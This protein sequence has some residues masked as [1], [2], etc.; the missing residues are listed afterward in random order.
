HYGTRPALI[1]L[2]EHPR[3]SDFAELLRPGG[4]AA[5]G[6]PPVTRQDGYVLS[7]GQV[8]M[9]FHHHFE[10]D[11]TLYNLPMVSELRGAIDESAVRGMW[12]DLAARHEALRSNYVEVDGEPTLRIRDDLGDFFSTVD[13]SGKPDPVAAARSLAAQS[14]AEPFDLE[15]DPLVRA[16]LVKLGPD[17]HV[18]HVTTHH[19]VNDGSSPRIFERE[20]PALYAAR[21]AG[22]PADL[23]PLPVRYRDYARWQR[24]LVASAVLDHELDYWK[25][26]LADAPVLRL[27]T[28]HPRPA[29]KNF[30]GAFHSFTIAP[31]L[32][33]DLRAVARRESVSFF[34][35][36]LA[37]FFLLMSGRSGQHDI[38][39]GTPTTGRNR[40]E[41]AGLIG[42]FNSTVALR[43]ELTG[44][45]D[46][47]ELF[48]RVQAVVL[49]ALEHQE[50]PFDR[51]VT[52][53]S[54]DRDL[55]R[56]PL[57]DVCHVHQELPGLQTLGAVS[58]KVFDQQH[59]STVRFG[60][61]P[62]GTAKFD[63]TLITTERDGEDDIAAG[64]EFSTELFTE[65]TAAAMC[66]E[67]VAHLKTIST[68]PGSYPIAEFF[69]RAKD[70]A[71]VS[72]PELL[73]PADR[74]RN[75]AREYTTASVSEKVDGDLLRR[76][77]SLSDND[78]DTAIL[79]GWTVLLA[80]YSG[81]DAVAIGH[82]DSGRLVVDLFDE[83]DFV[84][85]MDGIRRM[86]TSDL[87]AGDRL[88]VHY[89]GNSENAG[90]STSAGNTASTAA[91]AE[92]SL[93]WSLR[94]GPG[95]VLELAYAVELFDDS[96][97]AG[98]AADLR[99]LLSG[100]ADHP[101]QPVY[102]V[103]VEVTR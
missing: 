40:P 71:V 39:V 11:T 5:A 47:T 30:T 91:G 103:A 13:V 76:L 55:A 69:D 66:E 12:E 33:R 102:E 80:W 26:E 82:G 98:M 16:L 92:L 45:P 85:L 63:L 70:R 100:L 53:L 65:A 24:D 9:W 75:P 99:A 88:P 21:V 57:F 74:P 34:V 35:V 61:I 3:V 79:G 2:Y 59:P 10:P 64:L 83:P 7:F 101:D 62:A 46:V 81:Q 73:V 95:L 96:T 90:N 84:S 14:A 23:E 18:L 15:H 50:I 41:L 42:Y 68:V 72:A 56:S 44:E 1:D 89:A 36:L 86:R 49:G 38:V 31:D 32:A 78:L 43:V 8:R 20:L 27:P 52:A 51:V 94:D 19:S 77:E 97:A 6:L 4:S 54:G 29:R 28:D 87:P 37:A 48:R 17:D 25:R 58:E 22:E 60:G 67:Y 93:S